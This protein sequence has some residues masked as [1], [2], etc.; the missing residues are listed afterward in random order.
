MSFSKS[1]A[2]LQSAKNF[3]THKVRKTV[4]LGPGRKTQRAQWEVLRK[5]MFLQK[6]WS[7]QDIKEKRG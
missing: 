7:L 5:K 6:H 2:T 4:M 3:G 1:F